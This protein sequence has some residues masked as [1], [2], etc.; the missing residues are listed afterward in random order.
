M[1]LNKTIVAN[2][3]TTE[4]DI[5]YNGRLVKS[6]M[7]G[8]RYA[9]LYFFHEDDVCEGESITRAFVVPVE[10]PITRAKA[11]NAAEMVAYSL[12]SAMDVASFGASLARKF[13]ENPHD[14]ECS[15][16]DSFIEDVKQ[17]LTD[18]GI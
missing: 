8:A 1:N 6:G 7:P 12:N 9:Q 16:H 15:E 3:A 10:K 13:R 14:T 5:I 17:A 2:I 4:G 11:I 18:M